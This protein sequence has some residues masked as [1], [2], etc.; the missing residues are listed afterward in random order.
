VSLALALLVAG[1]G[2]SHVRLRVEPG[3]ALRDTP[4]EL[5][6]TGLRPYERVTVRVEE[7]SIHRRLWRSTLAA[8]AGS[9]GTV[10]LVHPLLEGVMTPVGAAT[11]AVFPPSARSTIHVSVLAGARVVATATA[12]R[13]L[14]P[15][16]VRVEAV[17]PPHASIYGE[18]FVPARESQA[19]PVLFF[20]G[21]E[22]GLATAD[23]ASLLAAHGHP[24]LALA[25][26]AEPGLPAQLREIPLEYFRRAIDWLRAQPQVHGRRVVVGGWS[27]GG[28]AALLV[29]ATYPKLVRAVIAIVPDDWASTAPGLGT[30]AAWT[31]RG[32]PVPVGPIPIGAIR[33]PTFAVGG[34]QDALWPSGSYARNI[35]R[36][37][38]HSNPKPT[39]LV[40][41]GAG[42]AV[43]TMLPNTPTLIQ[44]QSPY[45]LLDF[46]GT[47]AADERAR[48]DAWPRLLAW[49]QRLA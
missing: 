33:G 46:G 42:H 5:R 44:A 48:E 10:T 15:P 13:L 23:I 18:Y 36:R 20:G 14:R 35:A 24:V 32:R 2:G 38:A 29:G 16:G 1:C 43:G 25:Y 6:I 17:R 21:S 37:L 30:Q 47:R 4:L 40:Y 9:T 45:G 31:V 39:V 27:F 49:L 8:R 41:A 26:F 12:V 28:E 7:R 11:G 3:L 22:G 19:A 34:A